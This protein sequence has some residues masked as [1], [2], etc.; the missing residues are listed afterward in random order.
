MGEGKQRWTATLA[1]LALVVPLIVAVPA[2]AQA[3]CGPIPC[4]E[5]AVASPYVLDF[6]QDHGGLLDGAGIGTGFTWVDPTSNGDGYLPEKLAVDHAAGWLAITTTA[7]IAATSVNSLDNGLSVGMDVSGGTAVLETTVLE[8]PAGTGRY[9]QAGLWFGNGED[10]YVKLVVQS[11]PSG[12]HVELFVEVGG[13]RANQASVKDPALVGADVELTLT[14][15]PDDATVTGAYR[16]GEGPQTDVAT[17]SVPAAFFSGQGAV[18]DPAIGTAT[19]GGIFATH[20][21]ATTA[22]EYRFDGFSVTAPPAAT[23]QLV[24]DTAGLALV[25]AS[26]EAAPVTAEVGLEVLNADTMDF[27]ASTDEAWLAVSPSAGSAPDALVVTADPGGLDAGT[28][29]GNVTVTGD[30]GQPLRIGVDF[31]VLAGDGGGD[32]GPTGPCAP[33]SCAEVK[34]TAPY[35]LSF[36][37]DHG[38]LVDGAGT[39]TGFTW[40]D[41]PSKGLGYLPENLAVDLEAEELAITTTSGLASGSTNSLDNGLG[42]G[43]DVASTATL[44]TVLLSPPTGSKNYE[45]A[46]LWF[47]NDEDNYAKFVLQSTPGGPRV[48]LLSEVDGNHT[49]QKLFAVDD[50]SASDV[51][52]QLVVDPDAFTVSG[53]LTVDGG[54]P[55]SVGTLPVPAEFFSGGATVVDPEIGTKTF[56][57]VFASHR[58]A[59]SSLI[60]RFGGFSVVAEDLG[61]PPSEALTF[62]ASTLNLAAAT[63]DESVSGTVTLDTAGDGSATFELETDAAWVSVSPTAGTTPATIE[64]TADPDGLPEGVYRATVTATG[65]DTSNDEPAGPDDLVVVLT[66]GDPGSCMPIGCSLVVVDLPYSLDFAS[67]HGMILDVDGTGTG[68]TYVDPPSNGT[69]YI[70]ENLAVDLAAGELAITTTS[71]LATTD[72]NSL[73]NGLGVGLAPFDTD[74]VMNTTILDVPAGRG[75]YEQAGL[76]FG[77]DEDNYAKFVLQSSPRGT[78]IELLAEVDGVHTARQD[79][80]D[81]TLTGQDVGLELVADSEAGTVTGR[82]RVNGGPYQDFGTVAVPGSFFTDSPATVDPELGTATFAGLFGSHRRSSTPL[83]YRFGDFSV[84]SLHGPRL[85]LDPGFLEFQVDDGDAPPGTAEV[86][87]RVSSG[88]SVPFEIDTNMPWLEVTPNFGTVSQQAPVPLTVVADPSGLDAGLYTASITLI[89]GDPDI[90]GATVP[91]TLRVGDTGNCA[92]L[93]CSLIRVDLPYVLD[94]D[95]DAGRLLDRN[96]VGTGF[97]WIEPTTNGDGYR[98]ELLEVDEDAGVFRITTTAGIA[99]RDNNSLDNGIGVGV[100]A[101]SQRTVVRTTL[102]DVPG[103]TGSFE[104]AGLYW[105]NDE[106]NYLKFVVQSSPRGPRVEA[107][108]ELDGQAV[109]NTTKVIPTLPGSDIELRLFADPGSRSIQAS[110]S[111][112]GGVSQNLATFVVP[113]ELFSFDAAGTDPTIGTRTF[114]GIFA[115]HRS[116]PEPMVYT[117]E[118]FS[119]TDEGQERPRSAIDFDRVSHDVPYPTALVWGPDDRLYVQEMFGKIHALTFDD[120]WQVIDDEVFA[121]LGTRLALGLTVDPASTADDVI[122]WAAHSSPSLNSGVVNSSTVTRLSGPGFTVAEDFITGLPRALANHAINSIHFHPTDGRLFIAMGGSTGA[123]APNSAPSEFGDR[124]EQPLSAALLVADVNATG[125][126]GDCATPLY[127][128]GVPPSCDVEVFASGLRNMYDFTFHSNGEIYGPD[129]GLGVT[130]TYPPKPEPD[131]TGMADAALHN[132]GPQ[133]DFLHRLEEGFYYGHPNPYRDECVFFGG[134]QQNVAPLPNYRQAMH[135]LG[136]N[137]SANGTIEYTGDEFCGAMSGDL[138]IANYSVGNDLTRIELSADGTSVLRQSHLVG[139]FSNPLPLTTGPR[140]VVFVGEHGGGKVTTLVPRDAGCWGTSEP[141]PEQLLDPAGAVLEGKLYV[142]AGKTSSTG[143][144]STVYV[145]DPATEVWTTTAP[146]PGPGVE[147]AAAAVHDGRLYVFGGATGPFS[148]AVANTAV[149]DPATEAWTSLQPMPDARGGAAAAVLGDEIYVVGGMAGDGGSLSSVLVFDT[150]TGT[151]RSST[152]MPTAR[153]NPGAFVADGKLHVFGGRTRL[154]DGQT[155]DGQLAV[156]EMYDP[157][158]DSWE[159]RAEMPTG[160][161]TFV[162]IEMDGAAL[163]IGGEQRED[164]GAFDNNELYD[165]ATDQWR[166]LTPLPTARHGA[167]GGLIDGRVHVVGGGITGGSSYSGVHEVLSFRE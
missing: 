145:Y 154:S 159:N 12:P 41:P 102:T 134:S 36:G 31:E 142:I 104:Q 61:P 43:I 77:N 50:L 146:L 47:G 164:G 88:D 52:L 29:A 26:P 119:V 6:T 153:D 133:P 158:L 166:I 70:R 5:I 75:G 144:Q 7:G 20:R 73:D 14:A 39:G 27:T 150:S 122:L 2:V 62:S 23:P 49:G 110:Y 11:M 121:T 18:V 37:A 93:A 167:A 98:P 24:A 48:E 55:I 25:A 69:G 44:E 68:F 82:I 16:I 84:R 28:Y 128:F 1:S 34:V 58:R 83:E 90:N 56:A 64:V 125:F 91:V 114:A 115:S 19:F 97:S 116:G 95:G 157:E 147:D 78:R 8:V 123:G 86:Q 96:G 118:E 129:N 33:L 15:N 38:G 66:V 100:D 138:L 72:V 109:E 87:L 124:P 149:Y 74:V 163:V 111:L 113:G 148:G 131:C 130:G 106:D 51:G 59:S 89:S 161:R 85:S 120:D 9:E 127:E 54:M 160:R 10:D 155:V 53:W 105:S 81:N 141:L 92:L 99:S 165:A 140:G 117:F 107:L 42:V 65:I 13:Q 156:H 139:G 63:A 60:Y 79:R 45:Q 21:R 22:R 126:Q 76:W 108:L 103:G 4:D 46:G 94:F 101:P 71:G 30:I 152:P 151:W 32:P 35:E 132:P 143:H 67:D 162:T 57:G 3:E 112:N 40:V 135:D 136:D 17:F 137:R 80:V